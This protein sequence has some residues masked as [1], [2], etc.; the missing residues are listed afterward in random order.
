MQLS[1][2]LKDGHFSFCNT[3][4][5]LLAEL[6]TKLELLGTDEIKFRYISWKL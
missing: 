6:S 5:F 2:S 1:K 3:K 4:G